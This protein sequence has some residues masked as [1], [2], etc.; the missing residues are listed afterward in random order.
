MSESS[1]QQIDLDRIIQ[2][3]AGKRAKYVPGFVIYLLKRMIHLD[4]INSYLK[5]G[6]E[7]VEFCDNCLEY[8]N[9]K[10]EVEGLDNLPKEGRRYTFVSNHPLGAIDGVT[11]GKVLGKHYDGKIKY[12]V[13]D[14]LMNL[15]GLAPLCVPVNKIGGQ[16]RNLPRL[17]DEAFHSDEQ[18]VMFPAGIC[19]RKIDGKIQDLPWTK[20]FI[21]KS[22]QAK[23]DIVPIHFIG[24]N[25]ERFYTIANWCK[26]LRLKLN[27]A[28]FMLPGEMYRSRGSTY[29]VI[30]GKPIPWETF[31]PAMTSYEWAQAVRRKV[32][33]LAN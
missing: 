13:N 32:Y 30:I 26:M 28:M 8:L 7:G 11:L 10:I 31:T 20:A 23:R 22:I 15:K 19:S 16:S 24:R 1:I 18:M 9:V 33:E 21:T 3:R 12:L 29:K 4:F 6:Y 5:K 14:L 27:L 2:A 25:S 17:I